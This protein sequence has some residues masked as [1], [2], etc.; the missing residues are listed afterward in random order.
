MSFATGEH[1]TQPVPASLSEVAARADPGLPLRGWRSLQSPVTSCCFSGSS[2]GNCP[3]SAAGYSGTPLAKKLGMTEGRT[4]FVIGAPPT[5]RALLAPLPP[6]VRFVKT[7][8]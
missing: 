5:Y 2:N 3:V 1:H 6:G 8:V 4:V 7:A